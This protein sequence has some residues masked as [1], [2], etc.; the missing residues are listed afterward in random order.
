MKKFQKAPYGHYKWITPNQG[1]FLFEMRMYSQY[2][3][4][5]IDN[6]LYLAKVWSEHY[7]RARVTGTNGSPHGIFG[8]TMRYKRIRATEDNDYFHSDS[9]VELRKGT[10]IW[11]R[12]K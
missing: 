2:L 3:A 1:I 9:E 4:G 11:R 5:K 7:S 6:R 12:N 10:K 8:T